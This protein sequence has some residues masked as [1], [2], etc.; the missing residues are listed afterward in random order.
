MC[1]E[2]PIPV[3]G[4]LSSQL[5]ESQRSDG[6]GGQ[7]GVLVRHLPGARGHRGE[8]GHRR[9]PGELPFCPTAINS[10]VLFC[11][12]TRRS[13]TCS[14]CSTM[15]S[16]AGASRPVLSPAES[17]WS[18]KSHFL[19]CIVSTTVVQV[20]IGHQ[21]EEPRTSLHTCGQVLGAARRRCA[22]IACIHSVGSG[23]SLRMSEP[24]RTS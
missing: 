19:P 22:D 4:A 8:V 1:G 7:A 17:S 9:R 21:A 11:R 15:R 18:S 23:S 3:C 12:R 16:S 20:G 2:W 10:S 5:I 24:R 13:K 14:W 6:G